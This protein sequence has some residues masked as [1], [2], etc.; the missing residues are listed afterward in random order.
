M[1]TERHTHPHQIPMVTEGRIIQ[2]AHQY[3]AFVRL[4]TFGREKQF[5]EET[6][7]QAA[8]PA[9][10]AVLDVGCGTGTLALMVKRQTGG[11]GKVFGI[12][13]SPEMIQVAQDKAS[14]QK[15]DVNF[16]QGV[17][18][19]L[20]FEDTRF[21]IVLSTLMFHHLPDNLKNRGLAEIYRVL[22]PGGRLLI[23]DMQRPVNFLQRIGIAVMLHGGLAQGIQDVESMMQEAGYTNIQF[24]AGRWGLLGYLQGE[25]STNT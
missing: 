4:L 20:P 6:L 9:N 15:L 18:E 13:A 23:V 19:A 25:R 17:I 11:Q 8:I 3:D 12:D 7:R 14:W 24:S 22:K 10:A 2:W 21:D 5:R 1:N 16:Q